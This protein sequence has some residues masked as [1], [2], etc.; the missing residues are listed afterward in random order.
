LCILAVGM[1]GWVGCDRSGG[2]DKASSETPESAE[3]KEQ[4]SK[5]GASA[6][7][8]PGSQEGN[9]PGAMKRDKPGRAD[10]GQP[11]GGKMPGGSAED[12]SDA[13]LQKFLKVTEKLKPKQAELKKALD[14]AE[15]AEEARKAQKKVMEET[16]KA[17]EEVGLEF[18]RFREI[19]RQAKRNPKLQKKLRSLAAENAVKSG[20]K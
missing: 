3:S 12:I 7:N 1:L 6:G 19:S 13:E 14:D 10:K 16:R 17:S 4:P 11:P 8:K 5:P 2:G 9:K 18:S 20:N 15:N